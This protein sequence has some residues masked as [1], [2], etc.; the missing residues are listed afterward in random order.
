LKDFFWEVNYSVI[1]KVKD[2]E[3]SQLGYFLVKRRDSIAR[4]VENL[5]FMKGIE[6]RR[7]KMY[8]AIAEIELN[9][10][11]TFSFAQEECEFGHVRFKCLL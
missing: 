11:G 2:F 4:E 1:A 5:E 9:I 3:C 7:H 8:F 6:V 10:I